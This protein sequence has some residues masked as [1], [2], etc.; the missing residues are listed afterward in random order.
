MNI[1]HVKEAMQ[2]LKTRPGLSVLVVATMSIGIALL[3]TM[4]TTVYHKQ[5]V[6]I[7]HISDQ[8]Y[9][10]LADSRTP[11]QDPIVESWQFP[12]L[13]WNDAQALFNM[14]S[15]ASR[16]SINY[17]ARTV[18]EVDDPQI[19]PVWAEGPA[20]DHHYFAMFDAPFLFGGPWGAEADMSGEAVMVISKDLNDKLFHGQNSVGK[21]LLSD[22][23]RTT[24]IGVMDVW[25]IKTTFYDRSFSDR[26]MHTMFVPIGHAVQSNFMRA[27]R[28]NCE[29]IQR[30]TVGDPRRGDVQTLM[31]SDCGWVNLW[32]V[33][34]NDNQAAEYASLLR[35]YVQDQQ[36]LGRY[37][38]EDPDILVANIETFMVLRGG[39]NWSNTL[40]VMA[41]LFFGVCL[42]NTVGI[43]LA[44]FLNHT[45][46]VSLYRAL[47]ASKSYILKQHL[48]EV[49]LLGVAGGLLGIV[50]AYFGLELMFNI[51]MYQMD[52]DGDPDIVKTYFTLDWTMVSVAITVAIS[53][54]IVAGLYPIWKICNIPPASQLKS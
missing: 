9:V 12:A 16:Q 37:T 44:K 15:P 5:R 41:Y 24:I 48:I 40:L 46:R 26:E 19:R 28:I 25:P 11:E 52:Y 39:D 32:A 45:K 23:V 18:L 30:E 3:M 7:P 51:E 17:T 42:V 8:R 54:I 36:T 31:A 22:G 50:L 21:T 1:Q 2:S 34:E 49:V 38:R 10:V 43:L 6:P 20:T 47:G 53:S 33:M 14:Q 13:S 35:Q 27:Y 29:T 4:Q